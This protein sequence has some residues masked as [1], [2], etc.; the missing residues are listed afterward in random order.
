MAVNDSSEHE[1]VG[2]DA[3]I[4]RIR[5]TLDDSVEQLDVR[6]TMALQRARH[7]AVREGARDRIVRWRP[8]WVGGAALASLAVATL[9]WWPSSDRSAPVAVHIDEHAEGS[10]VMEA[11]ASMEAT[12]I[13]DELEFYSWL[14]QA[15]HAG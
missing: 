15:E 6:T 14:A 13:V 3:M 2:E 4:V 12:E 11:L 5:Q 8:L 9:L 7:R 10:A 1:A